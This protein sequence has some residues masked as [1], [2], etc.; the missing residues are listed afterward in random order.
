MPPRPWYKERHTNASK[1]RPHRPESSFKGTVNCTLFQYFK[2]KNNW[3]IVPEISLRDVIENK[4]KKPA[5]HSPYESDTDDEFVIELPGI[6]AASNEDEDND[7]DDNMDEPGAGDTSYVSC[8]SQGG[9]VKG[10]RVSALRPDFGVAKAQ[11]E[12]FSDRN[13]LYVEVKNGENSY[14]THTTQIFEYIDM[15]ASS[16]PPDFSYD[17]VLMLIDAEKTFIWRITPQTA[18]D[19]D[20]VWRSAKG[21]KTHGPYM[22]KVLTELSGRA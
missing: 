1:Y 5:Q 2:P 20:E 10:D 11:P 9:V 7:E 13:H 6:G 19:R 18:C 8:D 16:I 12:L 14:M 22:H 15:I 17:V 4:D 21:V 3:M